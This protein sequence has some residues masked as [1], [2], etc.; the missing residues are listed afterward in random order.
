MVSPWSDLALSCRRTAGELDH[1]RRRLVPGP[2]EQIP[3]RIIDALEV[4]HDAAATLEGV[5]RRL[6]TLADRRER[7][8]GDG[9]GPPGTGHSA[10]PAGKAH[11]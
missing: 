6:A 2:D 11:R 3:D 7:A 5:A 8:E 4:A 1:A 9:Y 10:P